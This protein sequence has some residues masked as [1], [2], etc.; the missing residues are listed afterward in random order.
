MSLK[1][2]INNCTNKEYH[3]DS[4]FLS[5]SD[6]KLLLKDSSQFYKEKILGQKEKKESPY[7]DEGTLTHA[8]ILEPEVINSDFAFFDG[9][10][11]QG[12]AYEAFKLQNPGKIYMSKSQKARCDYYVS[13]FLKRPEA[14]ALLKKGLPEH[15]ICQIYSG[16]NVKVRCDWINIEDGY[17]VDVK[18]SGYPT[19][20]DSFTVTMDQ[21]MYQLSAALYCKIAEIQY[22]KKFDFYFIA[23]S[24]K[25]GDCNVFKLSEAT[26]ERG[27]LQ[28]A[29]AIQIYK[30]CMATN[31]WTKKEKKSI[32]N[33]ENFEILE[34]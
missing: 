7:F 18:T 2:G 21:Y 12:D 17:I 25:E 14:V 16:M 23:I 19:D 13:A 8:L 6:F 28:I 11:K 20:L 10:R 22:G 15:T 31:D 33:L 4:T 30:E 1:I 34:I 26:R 32:F 9:L 24:K 27:L 29:Q 3:S 5:S